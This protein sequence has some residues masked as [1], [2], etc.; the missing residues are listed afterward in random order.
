MTAVPL[1][2][3][4]ALLLTLAGLGGGMLLTRRLSLRR[5][6]LSAFLTFL[7][8]L[9]TALRYRNER[10]ELLVDS[11]GELFDLPCQN[12]AQPF[13]AL[14][15][16]QIAAFPKRWRLNSRDMALLTEFGERLGT[17]DTEGQLAHIAHYRALFARQL[18]EA[19]ADAAQKS[20]LYRVLGLFV[21][22]S[23]ALMLL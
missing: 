3:C 7:S 10:I 9:S 1:K 21:G 16:G 23:A 13:A 2:L 22:V 6:F 14:W 8:N 11:S 19:S 18:E 4:G 12:E 17:T 15:R 20:R 5:E